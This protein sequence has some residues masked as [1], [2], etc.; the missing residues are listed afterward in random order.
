MPTKERYIESME[1]A[2]MHAAW[3][4]TLP[5]KE[6]QQSAETYAMLAYRNMRKAGVSP[7]DNNLN[8]NV[9]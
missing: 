7:F 1:W 6:G 9:E 3:L 5:P 2:G 8:L 4:T